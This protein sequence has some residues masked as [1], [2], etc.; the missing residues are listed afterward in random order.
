[1]Q[2][3]SLFSARSPAFSV[4]R[5]LGTRALRMWIQYAWLLS[6][7]SKKLCLAAALQMSSHHKEVTSRKSDG[8]WWSWGSWEHR[9][10]PAP[11]PALSPKQV[12]VPK[13][14]RE[15]KQCSSIQA[16]VRDG[17]KVGSQAWLQTR[18]CSA[19]YSPIKISSPLKTKQMDSN[20]SP[21]ELSHQLRFDWIYVLM[22]KEHLLDLKF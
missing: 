18:N 6:F 3:G 22:F 16:G 12:L 9:G 2:E 7:D 19:S 4:C 10:S 14:P 11:H 17:G 21:P 1:M 5:L 20:H 8:Q 15:S 13:F